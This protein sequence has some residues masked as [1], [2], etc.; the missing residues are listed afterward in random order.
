MWQLY[1]EWQDGAIRKGIYLG[2][3]L[4][5]LKQQVWTYCERRK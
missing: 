1:E 2:S 3:R 4:H 5:M